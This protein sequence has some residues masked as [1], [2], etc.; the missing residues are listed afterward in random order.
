MFVAALLLP[1]R[2]APRGGT[3]CR[4]VRWTVRPRGVGRVAH[5]R[6][7]TPSARRWRRRPRPWP[8]RTAPCRW[9]RCSS[10]SAWP[11]PP[12]SDARPVP[13]GRGGREREHH[14]AGA[15]SG[16]G[17]GSYRQ[18]PPL[19]AGA[20]YRPSSYPSR[21]CSTCAPRVAGGGRW[22]LLC[23][24]GRQPVW[25]AAVAARLARGALHCNVPLSST[26]AYF[27][28]VAVND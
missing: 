7:G 16:L 23:R 10:A 28:S 27:L 5:G 11:P 21:W 12:H 8:G 22:R 14:P 20:A 1:G 25:C 3:T 4:P 19:A 13:R 17:H 24:R 26:A 9:R 6:G 18:G 2:R 15:S